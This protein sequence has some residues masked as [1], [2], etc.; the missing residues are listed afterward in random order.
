MP[1]GILPVFLTIGP[2]PAEQGHESQPSPTSQIRRALS[3]LGEASCRLHLA[4]P[5]LHPVLQT[6][7]AVL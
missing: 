5:G 7:L 3:L 4:S 1:P 6:E 2:S